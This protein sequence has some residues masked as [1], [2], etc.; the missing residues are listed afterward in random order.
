MQS[1]LVAVVCMRVPPGVGIYYQT[2]ER[3][4]P[5]ELKTDDIIKFHCYPPLLAYFVLLFGECRQCGLV[6]G[7]Q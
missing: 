3:I 7:H 5:L 4:D 2:L 6:F 1:L